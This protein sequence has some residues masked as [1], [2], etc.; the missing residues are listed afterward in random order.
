MKWTKKKLHREESNKCVYIYK[1]WETCELTLI[2]CPLADL[3]I[4]KVLC[5]CMEFTWQTTLQYLLRCCVY[6]IPPLSLTR[7]VCASVWVRI[8]LC[9]HVNLCESEWV[10]VCLFLLPFQCC[11]CRFVVP[12]FSLRFVSFSFHVSFWLTK[13]NI[14]SYIEL[15]CLT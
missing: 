8:F 7:C 1:W 13:T 3:C 4:M 12:F 15:V 6:T 9:W 11:R 2:Y 14:Q 5:M 10:Y